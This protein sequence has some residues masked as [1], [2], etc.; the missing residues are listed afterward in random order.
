M[1]PDSRRQNRADNRRIF[2]Q[3]IFM[4]DCYADGFA[5]RKFACFRS[6]LALVL[7]FEILPRP[8]ERLRVQKLGG[9][10]AY[11]PGRVYVIRRSESQKGISG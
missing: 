8:P 6:G 10:F 4:L 1:A 3:I 9:S 11:G 7:G 5:E 2:V